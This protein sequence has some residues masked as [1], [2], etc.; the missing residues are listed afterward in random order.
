MTESFFTHNNKCQIRTTKPHRKTVS[1]FEKTFHDAK[2]A[3]L[4]SHRHP[5]HL[6]R[7]AVRKGK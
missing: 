2:I 6:A 4:F 3:D 7:F 5:T 1:L